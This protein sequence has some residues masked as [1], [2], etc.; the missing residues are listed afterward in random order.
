MQLCLLGRCLRNAL[1]VLCKSLP[2]REHGRRSVILHENHQ[3]CCN[4][5]VSTSRPNRLG[6]GVDTAAK[7][8]ERRKAATSP[9]PSRRM[10][11]PCAPADGRVASTLSIWQRRREEDYFGSAVSLKRKK[12]Q[13]EKTKLFRMAGQ[14]LELS[15]FMS[16][17][18]VTL[19]LPS[20]YGDEPSLDDAC[21]RISA[22]FEP[23]TG[24]ERTGEARTDSDED[25]KETFAAMFDTL[26]RRMSEG[27][28]LSDIL[29]TKVFSQEPSRRLEGSKPSDGS[30]T[31]ANTGHSGPERS[32]KK[33]KTPSGLHRKDFQFTYKWQQFVPK[34]QPGLKDCTSSADVSRSSRRKDSP[35]RSL[36]S[37][38]S[39]SQTARDGPRQPEH[40]EDGCHTGSATDRPSVFGFGSA[41]GGCGWR[42]KERE[43]KNEGRRVQFVLDKKQREASV[44]RMVDGT[45]ID[46]LS[47]P[48][49]AQPYDGGVQSS[50]VSGADCEDEGKAP[51]ITGGGDSLHQQT[52]QPPSFTRKHHEPNSRTDPLKIKVALWAERHELA[53]NRS[54][55][56][57]E[58]REKRSLG[59]RTGAGPPSQVARTH[60][61]S[62]AAAAAAA[63]EAVVNLAVQ[64]SGAVQHGAF[65]ASFDGG[66]DGDVEG[67][68]TP[69]AADPTE[70]E[71]RESTCHLTQHSSQDSREVRCPLPRT[72]DRKITP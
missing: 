31:N 19:T 3:S 63:K 23:Q 61:R 47:L 29:P 15:S 25:R 65:A 59:L 24:S 48:L 6:I 41:V 68:L 28:A 13:V 35:M 26:S 42:Q 66:K 8:P 36:K 16:E 51:V 49:A 39:R 52:V 54:F 30:K 37:E 43:V 22:L 7:I 71:A 38:R 70:T 5:L 27:Q 4:H 11:C 56:P 46:P 53:L 17:T 18:T 60:R 62:S 55:A 21:P 57:R 44:Y 14:Q 2:K 9:R 69:P 40:T 10:L 12:K 20:I 72:T 1:D 32:R 58:P 50:S 67:L 34:P 33:Q 45:V 64:A